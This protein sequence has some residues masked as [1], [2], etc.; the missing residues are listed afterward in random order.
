MI[1]MG[2]LRSETRPASPSNEIWSSIPSSK[3][4]S[5]FPMCLATKAT[6]ATNE[7]RGFQLG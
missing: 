4:F 2:G 1:H 6:N 5:V 3:G 7:L